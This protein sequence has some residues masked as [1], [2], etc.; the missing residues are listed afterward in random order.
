MTSEKG[1]HN[2]RPSG[3]VSFTSTIPDG[4]SP[5]SGG[6]IEKGDMPT[7]DE[8]APAPRKWLGIFPR[9]PKKD[10]APAVKDRKSHV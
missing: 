1:K 10:L 2:R 6:D 9:A 7:E 8:V 5:T 3:A 4:A